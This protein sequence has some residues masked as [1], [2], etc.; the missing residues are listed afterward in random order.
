MRT[1]VPIL[2]RHSFFEP[3]AFP[4]DAP[5]EEIPQDIFEAVL[6]LIARM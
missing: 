2:T 4:L 3:L 5:G 1:N 6:N